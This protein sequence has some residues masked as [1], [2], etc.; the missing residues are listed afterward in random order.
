MDSQAKHVALAAG[1]GDVLLRFPPPSG[2]H[3]AIW[4]QAAGSIVIEE[5]GGL[6]TDLTGGPLDFTAGSRLSN[7]Q[8]IAASNGDLHPAVI[9][10]IA[11]AS[12]DLRDGR[13]A[14]ERPKHS[15]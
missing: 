13:S 6:V 4:D 9:G 15:A 5:A 3:D 12:A 8:G 14:R 7:N 1:M 11:R 2:R 10:A